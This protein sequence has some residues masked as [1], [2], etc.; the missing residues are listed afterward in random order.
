MTYW[1]RI[2]QWVAIV[3]PCLTLAS[4]EAVQ[5]QNAMPLQ[6]IYQLSGEDSSF[7]SYTGETEIRINEQTG[8]YRLIH[9]HIWE[10]VCFEDDRIALG[11]SDEGKKIALAW[12]GEVLS[13]AEPYTFRVILSPVGFIRSFGGLSREGVDSTPV[14]F[15]GTFRRTGPD[16]L[17]GVFVP[18]DRPEYPTFSEEWV[19]SSVSAERPIW[20]NERVEIPSHGPI[21][22]DTRASLFELFDSFYE[23]EEVAPYLDRADFQEGLHYVIFDPTDYEFYRANPDVIRVIQKIVDPI[24]LAEAR[25]RNRAYSQSLAAKA[26]HFDTVTPIYHLNEAG[27]YSHY[28]SFAPADQRFVASS[29]GTLWTGVYAASQ[30]LRYL[31]TQSPEA[32]ENMRRALNGLFLCFDIAPAPGD[33]ARGVRL[34]IEDGDPAYV[35]G[36]GDYAQWDWRPG[37]NNDMLKGYLVGFTWGWLA[38]EQAG[39]DPAFQTRMAGIV[40]ELLDENKIAA[41]GLTNEMLFR[42]LSWMMTDDSKQRWRYQLI[43]AVVKP[44]LVSQGNGSLYQFGIS[45]WSGNHLNLQGLLSGFAI[46]RV[47]G[48]RREGDFRKGLRK[49]LE[50]LRYNRLGLYQLVAGTLGDFQQPPPE[51]A[52]AIWVMREFPAPKVSHAVDWSI[53][54]SFSLSPFPAL[55]WKLDWGEQGGLRSLRAYP[56]FERNVGDFLWKNNPF[57]YQ[58]PESRLFDGGADYLFAYWFGRHHQVITPDM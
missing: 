41:D 34:H 29:D 48:D 42:M 18:L 19:W 11:C 13:M 9:T 53:N 44:F 38:L 12:E 5:A 22:A 4:H 25:I 43:F 17:E 15:L 24:S 33:F 1:N 30:A 52:D 58:S 39:G 26:L 40:D 6:G 31:E 55:P 56:A 51:L 21:S 8:S 50:Q 3:L 27:I 16:T 37:A 47:M 35:R 7:G 49:G 28:D 14:E 2:L 46:A 32:L 54:P 20:Q 23:R 36:T 10:S 57:D 45:D